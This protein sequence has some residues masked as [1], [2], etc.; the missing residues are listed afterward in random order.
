MYRLACC[1]MRQARKPSN[2]A[3]S[4]LCCYLMTTMKESCGSEITT[5]YQ[6]QLVYTTL[7]VSTPQP[8]S[9]LNQLKRLCELAEIS[10]IHLDKLVIKFL[11]N[12]LPEKL[13]LTEDI[14]SERADR[15]GKGASSPTGQASVAGASCLSKMVQRHEH[16]AVKR[17]RTV[18][19]FME[20]VT[21]TKVEG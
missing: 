16:T 13:L 2:F 19:V 21:A 14:M 15:E 10:L 4:L 3:L 12:E 7:L 8:K 6:K 5:L 18:P 17:D 1:Y 9:K 11:D 20:H